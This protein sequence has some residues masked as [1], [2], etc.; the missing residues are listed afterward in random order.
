LLVTLVV[1]GI[2]LAAATRARAAGAPTVTRIADGSGPVSITSTGGTI[3]LYSDSSLDLSSGAS[4]G[5]FLYSTASG[6][7]SSQSTMLSDGSFVTAYDPVI[8]AGGNVLA[9]VSGGP[10]ADEPSGGGG[11]YVKDLPSGAFRALVPGVLPDGPM[12]ISADGSM[13]AYTVS[14]G[15][16]DKLYVVSTAGG[17][18]TLVDTGAS[19]DPS[20]SGDGRLLAFTTRESGLSRVVVRDLRAGQVEVV[21]SDSAGNPGTGGHASISPD[22]RFVGFRSADE[23]VPDAGP[24][25]NVYVKDRVTGETTLASTTV[26]ERLPPGSAS[27]G[28]D[29]CCTSVSLSSDGRF[30]AFASAAALTPDSAGSNALFVK[31]RRTSAI[32][33]VALG[34]AANLEQGE[35][36]LSGDGHTLVFK[37]RAPGTGAGATGEI[38][39]ARLPLGNATCDH[40]GPPITLGLSPDEERLLR[41]RLAP[42]TAEVAAART[43]LSSDSRRH[44]RNGAINAR[45]LR[46]L[47][48]IVR[49]LHPRAAADTTDTAKL[50]DDAK[51]A[52][53]KQAHDS[54]V[55]YLERS[56]HGGEATLADK[57]LALRDVFEGTASPDQKAQLLKANVTELIE[58]IGGSGAAKKYAQV[59]NEIYKLVDAHLSGTLKET[60][61]KS[62]ETQLVKLAK[63]AAKS[64]FGSEASDLVDHLLTLRDVIA[65][66][67]SDAKKLQALKDSIAGLSLT[68]LGKNLLKTPQVR[69]AMLG[70]ELGRTFGNRIAEDLNLIANFQLERDCAV[71][72]SAKQSSP[73]AVDYSQP[74]Q[75]TVPKPLWHEGWHCVIEPEGFVPGFPGGVVQATRPANA[76][77]KDKILWRITTAG[78]AVLYDPHFAQG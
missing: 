54:V 46:Q 9:V 59:I 18:P 7:F 58:R 11:I 25:I 14:D 3:A 39:L 35:F 62:L 70:F 45:E 47:S 27:P 8:A 37:K 64:Y 53:L 42:T 56:G 38:D 40:L 77:T 1:S 44:R 16:L 23:L 52:L 49:R 36:A 15:S 41:L 29:Y 19:Q 31:D 26:K 69:A 32:V 68:L 51:C 24:L 61:R 48:A 12:S 67:P 2:L 22:G 74:T 50:I 30:V 21:S 28:G 75:A 76:S 6:R 66:S 4:G 63:R 72:L 33:R 20:L 10:L 43:A 17:T 60:L 34:S 5:V 73:G 57:L 55:D 65:G 71:A 13:V 78:E